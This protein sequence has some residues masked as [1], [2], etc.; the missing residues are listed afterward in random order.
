VLLNNNSPFLSAINRLPR[1][2]AVWGESIRNQTGWNITFLVG[3]PA[4]DQNGK[5]LTYMCDVPSPCSRVTLLIDIPEG[6]IAESHPMAKTSKLFSGKT[7]T[8]S[9]SSRLS[10]ISFRTHFVSRVEFER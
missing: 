9:I 6:C 4:P 3:G 10:T 5:I 7:D 1:T 8:T 2:L